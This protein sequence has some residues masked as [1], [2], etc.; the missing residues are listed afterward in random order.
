MGEEKEKEKFN[1]SNYILGIVAALLIASISWTAKTLI[2]TKEDVSVLNVK[3]TNEI[4]ALEAI[5]KDLKY[6]KRLYENKIDILNNEINDI[7]IES[8]RY[9]KKI[10]YSYNQLSKNVTF[11]RSLPTI[12]FD[13]VS[14][15]NDTIR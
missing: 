10:R 13:S 8:I 5:S 1:I 9:N 15:I 6:T 7:K 11:T 12:R 2:S 3:I 14:F 4:V